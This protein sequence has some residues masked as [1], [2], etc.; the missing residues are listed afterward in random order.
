MTIDGI[1]FD[2]DGLIIDTELPEFLAWQDIY[3]DFGAKLDLS[4]WI[5]CVGTTQEVFD[6]I[7]NLQS[8]IDIPLNGTL[9]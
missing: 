7:M 5:T 6:P 3:R 9:I 2:F 4:D 1:I 8:Q